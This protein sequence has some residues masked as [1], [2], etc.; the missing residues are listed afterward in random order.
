MYIKL[1]QG[2]MLCD[3]LDTIMTNQIPFIESFW[4]QT[5]RLIL[6]DPIPGLIRSFSS[7]N[8]GLLL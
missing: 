6:S 3:V 7:G 4:I 1:S 5:V 8:A 2:H